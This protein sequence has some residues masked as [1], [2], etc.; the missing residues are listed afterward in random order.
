MLICV[1]IIS[2]TAL[3]SAVSSTL[4]VTLNVRVPLIWQITPFPLVWNP[5]FGLN[6]M[7]LFLDQTSESS[8]W[9]LTSLPLPTCW[10][11][12]D[13]HSQTGF[14]LVI[15]L[16]SGMIPQS[17]VP[18]RPLRCWRVFRIPTAKSQTRGKFFCIISEG[19]C[20]RRPSRWVDRLFIT[21][22]C[23]HSLDSQFWNRLMSSH[24]LV[25]Q[26]WSSHMAT[27]RTL[28]TQS[29]GTRWWS[30]RLLT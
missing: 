5:L 2:P 14:H 6:S 15:R 29:E 19:K 13:A 3:H 21:S 26:I 28:S 4:I 1:S 7:Y 12:M 24:L 18:L 30:A 23:F 10:V 16:L 27:V 22:L 20:V 17:T 8:K 9:R 25:I 11:P